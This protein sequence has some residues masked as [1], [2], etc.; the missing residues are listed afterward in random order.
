M[1]S[2]RQRNRARTVR[3]IETAA[4]ELFEQQGYAE[5]TVEQI[6]R[7][8]GVSS[9]TF[10]R[11]FGSKEEVLFINEQ[12]AVDELVALVAD[13]NDRAETLAALKE[14]VA[15]FA[16]SFL[17]DADAET[18]RATR[19]VMTTRELES[20]SMR[21]RLHW[22]HALARQ[23]ASERD[24]SVGASEVLVANLAIA[25]LTAAL[26]QWQAKPTEIGDLTRSMFKAAADR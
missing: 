25:C 13:R 17:N 15:A 6:V 24:R 7:R 5:T 16:H 12:D 20:R 4:L 21:M 26:W 19:L 1:T 2:L 22:E 11:Y 14:P 18:L 8:A 9:A 23:L 3:D 10:F